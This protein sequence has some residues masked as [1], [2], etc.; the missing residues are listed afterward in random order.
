MPSLQCRVVGG[1]S[2]F[3]SAICMRL[4]QWM[5]DRWV[6]EHDLHGLSE[7]ELAP[8]FERVEKLLN[9]TPTEEAVWGTR[10]QLFKKGAEAMGFDPSPI[11][12]SVDGCK[13]SA[14]CLIGCRNGAKMSTDRKGI[15]E[16]LQNGGK[17]YASVHI[18][19]IIMRGNKACG[20]L[21][22]AI[23]PTTGEKT[24]E[25][26]ISAKCV[27]MAAGA[28][29]TP[30]ILQRSGITHPEL[31][32]NLRAHPGGIMLARFPEDIQ[33]WMGATQG[34]HVTRFLP[35]G[36]KLEAAWTTQSIFAANFK[37][38]GEEFTNQ[39]HD[40]RHMIAWDTWSSGDS[41]DG[42]VR[43]LPGGLH[44]IQ[45][46]LGQGDAN[47]LQEGIAKLADMAFAIGAQKVYTVYPEPY[48]VLY[49]EDDVRKFRHARFE[50]AQVTTGS[51]HVFGTTAMGGNPDRYPCDQNG[52][53]RG[54]E[55]LY[56]CDSGLFPS[57]PGANPMLPL[58]AV[59]ARMGEQLPG[60][61]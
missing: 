54:A 20:V 60:W 40:M 32:K 27:I 38:V 48:A 12:R 24:H 2:V 22:R 39:V 42:Q 51:N 13:G 52:K 36:I 25:V 6:D 31:G 3:N 7:A 49:D 55:N 18:D 10:N 19:E 44:D 17:L 9:V 1:G 37:G 33:P 61:I 53:V 23:N 43:A 34:Y 56:V 14:A 28:F 21:G 46:N 26:R 59:A 29:H 35:E 8:Y 58:M 50:P 16:M 30:T 45:F 57:T 11:L 4:P 47:R 41:C 15:P 5:A